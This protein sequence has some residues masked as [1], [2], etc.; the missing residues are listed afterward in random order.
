MEGGLPGIT[1]KTWQASQNPSLKL[2]TLHFRCG[3]KNL[4]TGY[5]KVAEEALPGK[6][7]LEHKPIRASNSA[8][9]YRL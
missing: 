9:E 4:Y 1:A 2:A 3:K 5:N 6:K 7:H 8:L